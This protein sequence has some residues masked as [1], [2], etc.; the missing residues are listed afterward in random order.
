MRDNSHFAKRQRKDKI[1]M[2]QGERISINYYVPCAAVRQEVQ[3]H[4][5]INRVFRATEI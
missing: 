2:F 3:G 5:K 4:R 1:C